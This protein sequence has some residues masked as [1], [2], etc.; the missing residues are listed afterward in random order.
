MSAFGNDSKDGLK[1]DIDSFLDN[2]GTIAEVL[3][4]LQY[5]CEEREIRHEK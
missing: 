2:G 3:E 1:Y 5:I 4:V